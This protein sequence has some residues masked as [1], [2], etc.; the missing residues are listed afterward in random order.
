LANNGKL[1]T[2]HVLNGLVDAKGQLYWK[3][4]LP[5]PRRVFSPAVSNTVLK[6]MEKV[7]ASGTG[8]LAQ[9]PGYRIAGKTGTAQKANSMGGYYKRAKITSFMSILPVGNPRY[10]ILVVIDEPIGDNAFGST[11]AAPIARDVMEQLILTEGIPPQ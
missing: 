7:V 11:V 8:K 9:I 1:V 5:S 2:P 10:M 6:M 4:D 3:P